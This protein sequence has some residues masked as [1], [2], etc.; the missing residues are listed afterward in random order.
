MTDVTFAIRR[1]RRA[2]LAGWLVGCTLLLTIGDQFHVHFDVLAY[3]GPGLLW[4]QAWWVAPLFAASTIGFIVLAWPFAT[5]ITDPSD[6]DLAT[7]TAWF[8]GTYVATA[9]AGHHVIP[10]TILIVAVWIARVARRSDRAPVIAYS[11]I[12]AVAGTL[13][14]SFIN[15]QGWAHYDV[16]SFLLVPAWLPA[17]YLQGAPM[18]LALTHRLRYSASR[19]RSPAARPRIVT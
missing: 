6:R 11:V 9:V 4:G 17:L 10:L 7:G 1:H 2:L 16:A 12:L 19:S 8:F 14:E 15:H 18:A 13:V 5:R 3:P